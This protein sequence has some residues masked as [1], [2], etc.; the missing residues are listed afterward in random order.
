MSHPLGPASGAHWPHKGLFSEPK[1]FEAR[2]C[3]CNLISTW[4][5]NKTVGTLGA[6]YSIQMPRTPSSLVLSTATQTQLQS[7]AS[8]SEDSQHEKTPDGRSHMS[9]LQSLDPEAN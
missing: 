8:Q 3:P 5:T 6:S 4:N 1:P 2:I 7:C 9:V